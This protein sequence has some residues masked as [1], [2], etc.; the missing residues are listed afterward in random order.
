LLSRHGANKWA[1]VTAWNPASVPLSREEN[2]ARQR[3]LIRLVE[4]AGHTWIRGEG[5]G[6]DPTWTPEESLLILDISRGEA[7]AL[8]KQF[9]QLA[10]VAGRRGESSALLPSAPTPSV[11]SK[12]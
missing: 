2:D 10:I 12:R 6:K 4:A 5:R 7:I 11:R 3:E 1:F 9:G 8:G